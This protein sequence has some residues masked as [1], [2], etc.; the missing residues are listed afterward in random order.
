VLDFTK[1][2]SILSESILRKRE[3]EIF[4][5]WENNYLFTEEG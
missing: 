3:G 2:T 1:K 4:S 5:G